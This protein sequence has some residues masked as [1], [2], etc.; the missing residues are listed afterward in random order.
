MGEEAENFSDTRDLLARI[1]LPSPRRQARANERTRN[2]V[3]GNRCT[4]RT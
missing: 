3:T 1:R 2:I 4:G